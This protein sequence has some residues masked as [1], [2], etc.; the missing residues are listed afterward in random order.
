MQP[1]GRSEATLRSYGMNLLRW[2]RFCWATGL[3]WDRVT[4][5]GADDFCRWL[6]IAGRPEAAAG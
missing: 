1:C 2:F 5:A 3:E 4:R 6:L